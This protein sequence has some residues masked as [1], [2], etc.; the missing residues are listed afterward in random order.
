[1][2]NHRQPARR[3]IVSNVDATLEWLRTFDRFRD[4][5]QVSY[6]GTLVRT[7]RPGDVVVGSLPLP[8]AA[9]ICDRGAEYWHVN[10]RRPR[11][12]NRNLTA[13]QLA[14][15]ATVEHYHIETRARIV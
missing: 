12:A 10:F 13:A 1:M 4:F 9:E 6:L 14:E 11:S 3:I 2:S 15:T 7:L 5:E 8:V